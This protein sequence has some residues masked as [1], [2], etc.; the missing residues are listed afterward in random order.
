[1]SEQQSAARTALYRT[2][3]RWHFYA[4]L[5]VMPF[6][7][8]LSLTGAFYLFKP[9]VERW[10]ERAFQGL[11]VEGAV[12]P[13]VQLS[14]ALHAFPGARFHSYRLPERSGDAAMIHL[15]LEDGERMRDVF[16]S[17]QGKVLGSLDPETR[18]ME[19]DKTIHGSLLW[20]R[21][22]SWLVE[23]A[24]C[25]AI[26]LVL[27]GLYLWWPR[28]G[29]LAGV[30]WP[31]LHKGR[32]QFWRDL[33]A[34]TGF[35]VAGLALVLLTTGLPWAGVWGDAFKWARAETGLL[36]G[37]QDWTIGGHAEHDHNAML[38]MEAKGVPLTSL[39]QIVAKAEREHLAFPV[40]IQAPGA[41]MAW[42]VKSDAQNRSL[43]TTLSYDMTDGR[44]LAREEFGD[45]H[46]ID[47]AV[48]YGI[49]W[50]EG[51]L[52]G[53]IN[54]L[55]GVLTAM[56]LITLMISGFVLWRR[57]KPEGGL[58]APPASNVPAR[59]GGVTAIL[60]VLAALMPLLAA[61]LAV[62]VVLEKV[63]LPRMPKIAHWLGV[64][65]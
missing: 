61:S 31:R 6:I 63:V 36:H 28:G 55:I 57:R 4:G 22:G 19:V 13:N 24:A 2:I 64:P 60:L 29:G 58:G 50:H 16:V 27:S 26:V 10:E 59:I 35:W 46:V 39:G 32:R 18:L 21:T 33:H 42:T 5:F 8:I 47:R 23:L 37:K 49:A 45:R 30:L 15:A 1:M 14:A 12:S 44:L 62:L 41:A 25:W 17:P 53:W 3:W 43:R 40:V 48:G 51:Q 20:G 65:A 52:F 34:V 56:A 11:P 9:Q 38:A 54:Q 7:L